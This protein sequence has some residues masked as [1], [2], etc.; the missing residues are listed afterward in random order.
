M[1]LVNAI[2][3]KLNWIACVVGGAYWG[4]FGVAALVGFSIYAGTSKRDLSLALFLG[5][6]GAALDTLWITFGWLDYG[7]LLAPIW[8]VMLWIGLALCLNHAMAFF[9]DRPVIGGILSGMAAPLTYLSGASLGAVVVPN[10][11]WLAAIGVVW[12]GLFF[13]VFSHLQD[14]GQAYAQDLDQD[15]RTGKREGVS[16]EPEL[17]Q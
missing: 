6:V 12:A 13:G 10:V 8:I 17:Q 1:K 9:I 16:G 14:Q 2:L 11:W 4:A 5:A 15:K 7:T 3:F